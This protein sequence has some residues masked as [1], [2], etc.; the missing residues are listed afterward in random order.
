MVAADTTKLFLESASFHAATIRRTSMR[1]GLRTDASARFEKAQDPANA[2]L[3]VHQYLHLLQQYCPAARAAGP[4]VDPAGF[5]Y[6]PKTITLRRARLLMKLG[7]RLDDDKVA[8]ILRS[9]QFGVTV[10]PVGFD[11]AVPSFRATKD[12]AIE[13]DLVEIGRAHV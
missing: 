4:L 1:L 12:I 13:D 2:E 5:R 3:A 6:V 11:V 10:T 9:L 7:V 8:G